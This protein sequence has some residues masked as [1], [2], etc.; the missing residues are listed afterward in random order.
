MLD[1]FSLLW[2]KNPSKRVAKDR[3]KIV[4]VNDRASCS[5]QV[6]D[7]LKTDIVKTI[8]NYME[9]SVDDLDV[10]ITQNSMED[11][12]GESVPILNANIPIKSIRKFRESIK[13]RKE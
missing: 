1:L 5:N 7:M 3:L 6:L 2:R 13:R 10:Q 4:L 12:H 9:I 8:S 11:T